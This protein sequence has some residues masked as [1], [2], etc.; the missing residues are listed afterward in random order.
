MSKCKLHFKRLKYC[1]IRDSLGNTHLQERC[2]KCNRV[3][4][5]V[6]LNEYEYLK[7]KYNIKYEKTKAEI[8]RE[9]ASK[10]NSFTGNNLT[11]F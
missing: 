9:K 6:S 1:L 8:K 2:A 11:L 5:F 10:P 4:R 7:R 3:G